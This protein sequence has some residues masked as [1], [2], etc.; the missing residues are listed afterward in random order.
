MQVAVGRKK[1]N[2]EQMPAR[3]A[4]GTLARIDSV[5]RPKEKRSDLL[6][7][8]IDREIVRRERSPRKGKKQ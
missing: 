7:A 5:L 3:F 6:R 2:S 1:I 8:A 4:L